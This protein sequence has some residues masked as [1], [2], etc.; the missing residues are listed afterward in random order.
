MRTTQYTL[1]AAQVHV[2]AE[3]LCHKHVPL[4]DDRRTTHLALG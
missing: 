1:T 3:T 2:Y 4:R